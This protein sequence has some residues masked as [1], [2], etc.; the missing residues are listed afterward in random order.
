MAPSPRPHSDAATSRTTNKLRRWIIGSV[1]AAAV[2]AA[3]IVARSY[4]NDS[5]AV[6][7]APAGK[8][9]AEGQLAS[10]GRPT[11]DVM[12]IVNGQD[13]SRQ[14]LAQ[15]CVERHGKEVL[16]SLVNKRLI[17]HHCQNRQISVSRQEI[18]AEIERMAKRFKLSREHWLELLERER[19]I[20]AEEYSR[21]VLWPTLALRK[22]AAKDLT[23]GEEEL[24]KAYETQYGAS[25]RARLMLVGNQQ[26]A[27]Q[28]H[29]QLTAQPQEF[30]RLAMQHSE[31]VNS[32]SI[33]GLIQPIRRHVGEPAIERAAFNL[34]PGQISAPI[35]LEDKFVILKCEGT[36]PARE[37]DREQARDELTESIRESK[38]RDV[39]SGLFAK[40]Q[41]TAVI[42]NVLNNPQLQQ[43]MPGVVA[44]VNGEKIT[45]QELGQECLLRHGQDVLETEI[46]HLLLEQ[47]LKGANA[48]VV[49]ADVDAEIA[50][51]ATLSGVVTPQGQPDLPKWIKMATEEQGMSYAQYVRDAVWPSVA[52]KRLTSEHVAVTEEDMKKGFEANYGERVSCRAIVLGNM[53]RAQEVWEKARGNTSI[54]Y[55]GD[56]A[57]EY[58]VEPTS[59]AL[60]GEVPPIRLHGGQ[61]QLENVAF[62]LQAGELSGVIQVGDKFVV[63]KCEGR[64]KPV[65]VNAAEVRDVLHRDI[66]E[67]KLRVAMAERFEKIRS[68]SRI[69]NYLA[70]TSHAPPAKNAAQGEPRRDTAVRQTGGPAPR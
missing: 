53:R 54:D 7:Q 50:H 11:H 3:T 59:K 2:I 39:A 26:L 8:P 20:K 41:E 70:G 28:L 62:K 52:L 17:M 27:Q 68:Q 56:L 16:E 60:R 64:T 21:D 34:Q 19:G 37:M 48:T 61:P 49:Q 67:K 69:D 5:S 38:L 32:A 55:F 30:A 10:P 45:T 63:L 23:V 4:M 58:S 29:Q 15:A 47:A 44:T 35:P 22:L 51:A 24:Q 43:S 1:G 57:E 42:Q 9:P 13:I 46:S 40:L 25:V 18:D 65:E 66:Y 33:G 14:R 6:A 12:A 31:D 36:E